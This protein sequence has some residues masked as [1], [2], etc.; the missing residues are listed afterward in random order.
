[1]EY[2]PGRLIDGLLK[3]E[4]D[5]G[6]KIRVSEQTLAVLSQK[7]KANVRKTYEDFLH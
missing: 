3:W 7:L 5:E 6:D 2:L 4:A 1:M